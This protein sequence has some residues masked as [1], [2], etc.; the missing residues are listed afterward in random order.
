MKQ[1]G[2]LSALLKNF[3]RIDKEF[4]KVTKQAV[5]AA[6]SLRNCHKNLLTATGKSAKL[7]T[8][9]ITSEAAERSASRRRPA[10][11]TKRR[12]E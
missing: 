10:P 7:N 3:L 1:T 9:E 8:D 6:E 4:I 11:L 12:M 2:C 5:S